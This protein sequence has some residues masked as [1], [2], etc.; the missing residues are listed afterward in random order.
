[1]MNELNK[2]KTMNPQGLTVTTANLIDGGCDSTADQF[3]DQTIVRD[4][5]PAQINGR[6]MADLLK[7][8]QQ[9]QMITFEG[10][11]NCFAQE[12]G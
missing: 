4:Y 3:L 6:S 11:N 5:S 8:S 1:M 10:S 2:N 12:S 7:S 9:Q